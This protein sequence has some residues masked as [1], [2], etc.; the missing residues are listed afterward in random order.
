[1]GEMA[2]GL[3]EIVAGRAGRLAQGHVLT[4]WTGC[5]KTNAQRPAGNGMRLPDE[6]A[7]KVQEASRA[8]ALATGLVSPEDVSIR[9]Y[10]VL[11][12]EAANTALAEASVK[13]L[14][15]YVKSAPDQL[16]MSVWKEWL[17]R[18]DRAQTLGQIGSRVDGNGNEH[19]FN[20]EAQRT[21]R[22]AENGGTGGTAKDGTTPA[23]G[24]VNP[25]P[26]VDA[27]FIGG[28]YGGK[29]L[30]V[31]PQTNTIVAALMGKDE[32]PRTIQH[33]PEPI[34]KDA[35]EAEAEKNGALAVTLYRR[36]T[37]GK[38]QVVWKWKR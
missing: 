14:R 6:I 22:T 7:Q 11:Y 8:A 37:N 3:P 24:A 32:T 16:A 9:E 25:V 19:D 30:A 20:A 26:F 23:A 38:F 35:L 18:W 31:D 17:K 10:V 27:E 4:L 28:L 33:S 1:M 2:A 21:Q 34:P 5:V 36:N 15:V 12:P 29:K 13:G